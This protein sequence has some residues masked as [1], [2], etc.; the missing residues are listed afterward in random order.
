MSS[1]VECLFW[2]WLEGSWNLQALDVLAWELTHTTC[3][4]GAPPEGCYR[5]RTLKQKGGNFCIYAMLEMDDVD[6]DFII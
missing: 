2:R 1:H 3:L 4:P 5:H 6:I